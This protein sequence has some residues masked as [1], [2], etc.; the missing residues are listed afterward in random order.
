LLSIQGFRPRSGLTGRREVSPQT[1]SPASSDVVG[2]FL[3]LDACLCFVAPTMSVDI[4]GSRELRSLGASTASGVARRPLSS[5][6]MR[7]NLKS[8]AG[9][10]A[11]R[12]PVRRRERRV[13][14]RRRRGTGCRAARAGNARVR[15]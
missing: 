3:T 2:A 8:H 5:A 12:G 6:A 14:A 7:T 11:G 1:E 13:R 9:F 15:G 10:R 4:R